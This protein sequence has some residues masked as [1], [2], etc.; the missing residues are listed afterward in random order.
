MERQPAPSDEQNFPNHLQSL[1]RALRRHVPLEKSGER[2]RCV[3]LVGPPRPCQGD[4]DEDRESKTNK[5]QNQNSMYVYV[6]ETALEMSL[7]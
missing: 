7:D 3:E 2:T 5:E 1:E 6:V 4:C